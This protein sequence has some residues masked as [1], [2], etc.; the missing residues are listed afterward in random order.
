MRQNT[1]NC[2]VPIGLAAAGL[3][4]PLGIPEMGECM[5]LVAALG[6]FFAAARSM[7][8]TWGKPPI[9]SDATVQQDV[10][11]NSALLA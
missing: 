8:E 4:D 11:L 3:V 6:I 5:M 7:F 9:T 10:D 1:L 2:D